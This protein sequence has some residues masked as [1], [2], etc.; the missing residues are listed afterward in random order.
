M[1]YKQTEIL[2]RIGDLN[3]DVINQFINTLKKSNERGKNRSLITSLQHIVLSIDLRKKIEHFNN[4][5]K[6]L[7]DVEF[8]FVNNFTQLMDEETWNIIHRSLGVN[9]DTIVEIT[10]LDIIKK[11]LI[12]TYF[13][14]KRFRFFDS[15]INDWNKTYKTDLKPYI[16]QLVEK[17]ILKC[18]IDY[19]CE[20]CD[21]PMYLDEDRFICGVCD[22]VVD[23]DSVKKYLDHNYTCG[24][25]WAEFLQEK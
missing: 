4:E 1:N 20:V 18:E 14:D 7:K 16:Q 22:S 21:N 9:F 12:T 10:D 11:Q 3:K 24:E 6:L 8:E 2:R 15:T 5:L 25:K 19:T 17:K 23:L 13:N